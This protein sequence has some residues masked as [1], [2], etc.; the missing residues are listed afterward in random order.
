MS[1]LAELEGMNIYKTP[2]EEI[3]YLRG[4]FYR[5]CEIED[6]WLEL[7]KGFDVDVAYLKQQL[8]KAERY[9]QL[10]EKAAKIKASEEAEESWREYQQRQAEIQENTRRRTEWQK[11]KDERLRELQYQYSEHG[12]HYEEIQRVRGLVNPY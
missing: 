9:D 3:D 12:T 5:L 7:T 6:K 10:V 4:E 8:E 11:Q 2:Q 1:F